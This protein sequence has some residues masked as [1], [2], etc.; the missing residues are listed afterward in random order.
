MNFKLR[1][2]LDKLHT[3]RNTH[4]QTHTASIQKYLQTHDLFI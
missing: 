2:A 3:L 4:T 1:L